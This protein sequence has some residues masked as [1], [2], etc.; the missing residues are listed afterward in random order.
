MADLRVTLGN[1]VLQNPILTASGTFGY[2]E[3]YQD[4]VNLNRVGGLITKSITL[5]PR[6]GNFPYRVVE[7][8]GGMLNS[9]GLANVGVESFIEE[10]LPFLQQL[11][12]AVIVNIAGS[13]IEEYE[14]VLSRL[15]ETEGIDAY[16]INLS[17][18]NVK[19]GGLTFG[20]DPRQIV[21]ITTALRKRTTKPLIVKLTPNV[22]DMGELAKAAEDG[23]ADIIS[24]INT[25]VGMAVNVVQR[26]PVLGNVTG[27]LSGPAIKPIALARIWE[28]SQ[29][30]KIPIIG[31]GGIFTCNDVLEFLVVGASAVQIGTANFIDPTISEKLVDELAAYCEQ[32][33]IARIRD[34]IGT[35]KVD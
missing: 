26:R 21:K 22:S 32:N 9:I 27:G 34:L 4:F 3:E 33:Q 8:V 18:P 1:L 11:R 7:T 14:V 24:A 12:C 17:C 16:E 30:V 20:K 15:E 10:K 29:K 35:L 13:S 23:G 25:I 19:E 28:I 5:K 31:I 2:G 6:A